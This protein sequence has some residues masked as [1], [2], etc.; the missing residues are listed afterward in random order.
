MKT[1]GWILVFLGVLLLLREFQPAFLDW[2]RPYAPYIKDAFWG[3]TL[4]AFGLYLT[5]RKAAKKVV[6]ILYLLYLLLYLVV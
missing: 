1:L 6:L 5:L 4:I 3:V 2:L